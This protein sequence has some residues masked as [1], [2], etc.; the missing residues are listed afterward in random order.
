MELCNINR[1]AAETYDSIIDS[2]QK[3]WG[4][5]DEVEIRDVQEERE[6]LGAFL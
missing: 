2:M 6:R 1:K 3:E 4:M 5:K